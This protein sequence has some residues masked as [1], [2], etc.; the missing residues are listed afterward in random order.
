M[1]TRVWDPRNNSDDIPRNAANCGLCSASDDVEHQLKFA[2]ES[3][4]N[5]L[6]ELLVRIS[7][8]T[9]PGRVAQGRS[10]RAECPSKK[11]L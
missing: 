9:V 4:F 6:I 11:I 3:I 10:P 8:D 1:N 2:L 7:Q 5:D